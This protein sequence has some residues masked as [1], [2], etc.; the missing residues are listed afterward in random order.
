[1][2]NPSGNEIDTD[3][4]LDGMAAEQ[5]LTEMHHQNIDEARI[6][7]VLVEEA[8]QGSHYPD[9]RDIADDDAVTHSHDDE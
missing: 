2:K 9:I 5:G 8:I 3:S 6:D 7:E 1:M 4:G